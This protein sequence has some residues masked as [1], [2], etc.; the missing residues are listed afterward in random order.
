MNASVP[1][2][3][4]DDLVVRIDTCLTQQGWLL[5]GIPKFAFSSFLTLFIFSVGAKVDPKDETCN[6][7]KPLIEC[8]HVSFIEV[9]GI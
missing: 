3:I 6:T 1:E 9:T 2:L 7:Y 8:I 4:R 5:L